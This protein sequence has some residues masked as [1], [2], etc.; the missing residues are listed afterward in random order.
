MSKVISF[1]SCCPRTHRE[2]HTMDGSLYRT[3]EVIDSD[4]A[5]L[6]FSTA[7]IVEREIVIIVTITTA[8]M[9]R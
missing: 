2:T 7:K 4:V 6:S 9:A 5:H 3:T 1:K 8:L